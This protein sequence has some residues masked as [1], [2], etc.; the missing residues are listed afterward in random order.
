MRKLFF[1]R[2]REREREKNKTDF[3][4]DKN[5]RSGRIQGFPNRGLVPGV[6]SDS[7]QK[8]FSG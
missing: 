1:E 3:D 6:I 8:S 2:G 4:P 7:K 5:A